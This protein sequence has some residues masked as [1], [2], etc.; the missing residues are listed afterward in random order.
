[1]RWQRLVAML[2]RAM[3]QE[4]GEGAGFNGFEAVPMG[5]AEFTDLKSRRA[6]DYK[7]VANFCENP[8]VWSMDPSPLRASGRRGCCFGLHLVRA[9]PRGLELRISL[10]DA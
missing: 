1:M 2:E 7:L 10:A 4:Y 6:S 3:E 8:S 5:D 9:T